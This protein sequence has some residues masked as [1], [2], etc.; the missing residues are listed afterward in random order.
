M[1]LINSI[2]MR[3]E[4]FT[5]PHLPPYAILSHTWGDEEVTFQEFG[6]IEF[7]KKKAGFDKIQHSCELASAKMLTY[8]WVDTCCIDKSSSAELLEAINSMFEWYKQSAVCF[9]YLSDLAVSALPTLW[10]D[11]EQQLICRW[12]RRGWTLQEL[13]APATVEFYDGE[14]NFKGFKTNPSVMQQLIRMTGIR[15]RNVLEDS[16]AIRDIAVAERMS[17]ASKRETKRLE[18]I[19]YCLL[20]IFQGKSSYSCCSEPR[21]RAAHIS[22]YAH[23]IWRGHAR[24]STP[25][26]GDHKS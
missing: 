22:K 20:G 23:V 19:A 16:N 17:W 25:T 5:P 12:F 14:W 18:D 2:S 24:I 15:S 7:A 13:L 9:T 6:N 10:R 21:L 1:W 4:E 11:E 8:V 3:L 26:G